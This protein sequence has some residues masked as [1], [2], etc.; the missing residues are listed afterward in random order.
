MPAAADPQRTAAPRTPSVLV[1]G[2]VVLDLLGR[3]GGD[4][5]KFEWGTTPQCVAFDAM[6]SLTDLIESFG[7]CAANITYNL[8]ALGVETLLVSTVGKDFDLAYRPHLE[9]AGV[10]LSG[11]RVLAGDTRTPRSVTITDRAGRQFSFWASNDVGASD[12]PSILDRCKRR[13][14]ELVVVASNLPS[15]MLDHLRAASS[16][17]SP[18]LWAP[19][20]DVASLDGDGLRTAWALSSYVIIND[21]EWGTVRATLGGS[22]PDW[23]KGLRAVVVTRGAGGSTILRKGRRPVN[24]PAARPRAVLD[25]T[26]SGDAY[27]AGFAWG[28]VHGLDLP[29]CARAGSALAVL[30]L[31]S[32][33]TQC[34]EV[35]VALLK[36]RVR[37]DYGRDVRDGKR[38]RN[39]AP[40]KERA[41]R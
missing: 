32:K 6:S 3:Y 39:A 24:V 30:N 26:G 27:T 9:R 20:G 34:H 14:P 18:C 31:E 23:P 28:L 12:S 35:S 7:G 11:I 25:P 5:D 13:R 19:G 29:E 22:E 21:S 41:G 40:R 8:T 33:G 38:R 2:A 4:F 37:R 36:E 15:V 10:D 1:S 16:C 17:G